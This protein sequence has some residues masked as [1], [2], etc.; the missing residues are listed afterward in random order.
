MNFMLVKY[1]GD[2]SQ[3]EMAD[4]Y[5]V[6]QQT[7][8]NWEQGKVNPPVKTMKEISKDSGFS[9]ELLFFAENNKNDL[10]KQ[11]KTTA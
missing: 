8:S 7:W 5:N 9:V 6:T 2:R 1:R 10:L 4:K 11:A 3:Q